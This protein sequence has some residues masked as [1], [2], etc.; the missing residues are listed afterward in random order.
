MSSVL[1]KS[2]AIY[3]VHGQLDWTAF[4]CQLPCQLSW[5]NQW[6][7]TWFLVSSTGLASAVNYRIICPDLISGH[8]LCSW[9]ARLG[10]LLLSLT[11]S[12]VLIKWVAIYFVLG[13]FDW[14]GYLCQ[15]PWNLSWLNQWLSTSYLDSS[16]GLATAVNYR[17]SCPD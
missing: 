4:R 15:L 8:L 9:S 10:R 1:I 16:T 6:P 2:V 14:T 3:F 7:S 11:V 5:L 13:Q 17:V 12:S